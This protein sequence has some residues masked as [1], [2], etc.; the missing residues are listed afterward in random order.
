L[1]ALPAGALLGGWLVR[2][3]PPALISSGGMAVAAGAL[4]IM[5]TWGVGSLDGFTDDVV[6]A[7]AGLGFGLAIAPVN[8]AL[9][10]ATPRATHGVVSA[11]LIVARMIGMLAGL[12]AL[13]AIGLRR[14]YSVQSDIQSPSTLCPRSP[15][16]CPAYDDAVREAIVAQLQATF[17]AATICACLAALGAALLL[18]GRVVTPAPS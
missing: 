13:T 15:T 16:N 5:S 8:A 12:S 9:L 14:L 10:A 2:R 4:G 18:R 11:L 7:S 3:Y 1:V 6:L 17:A